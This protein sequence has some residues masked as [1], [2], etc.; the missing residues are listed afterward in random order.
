M[1]RSRRAWPI[2]LL[3]VLAACSQGPP[4]AAS[5][6]PSQPETATTITFTSDPYGFRVDLP[7][8]WKGYTTVEETW[9]GESE[10]GEKVASGPTI[11]LRSPL[12]TAE[13]PRQDIPIMIFT[14]HQWE[15]LQE[16]QFQI[17]AAPINPSELGRNDTYVF[18][19]PARYNYAFLPGYQE[20]EKILASHPLSTFSPVSDQRPL[21]A[22]FLVYVGEGNESQVT[23]TYQLVA[24][25]ELPMST[26]IPDAA[27]WT[28]EV[29]PFPVLRSDLQVQGE[30]LSLSTYFYPVRYSE[31]EAVAAYQKELQ[32]LGGRPEEGVIVRPWAFRTAQIDHGKTVDVLFLGHY[33]GQFFLIHE[34]FPWSMAEAF[35]PMLQGFYGHWQWLDGTPLEETR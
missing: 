14:L 25:L 9:K 29:R 4:P 24:S 2:L 20:V 34:H 30:D 31:D 17:G 19:L 27:S 11:L 5:P 21:R 8:D 35:G 1:K 10:T 33:Q 16:G 22:D 7:S 28:V 15:M 23:M 3:L 13:N 6:N 18:A 26:Y 32:S 12:W